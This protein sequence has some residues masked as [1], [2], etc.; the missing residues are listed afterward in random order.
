MTEDMQNRLFNIC[1]KLA[2]S[3]PNDKVRQ[4]ILSEFNKHKSVVSGPLD[5]A[6]WD[7]EKG[8]EHLDTG[9]I[10][11]PGKIKEIKINNEHYAQ[12]KQLKSFSPPPGLMDGLYSRVE[13]TLA[14]TLGDSKQVYTKFR[15][16]T[17]LI[18]STNLLKIK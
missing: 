1:E 7:Q 2:I 9:L 12:L 16:T 6:R 3:L 14:E 5:W 10:G 4:E 11:E 13:C 17:C 8:E 18:K 15:N